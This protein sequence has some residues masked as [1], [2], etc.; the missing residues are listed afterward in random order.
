MD[1]FFEALVLWQLRCTLLLIDIQNDSFVKTGF[2]EMEKQNI[3][4]LIN[5]K[6]KLRC[7]RWLFPPQLILAFSSQI[8][9]WAHKPWTMH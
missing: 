6:L 8:Q 4:L 2:F 9:A 3:N 1:E 5:T 7:G